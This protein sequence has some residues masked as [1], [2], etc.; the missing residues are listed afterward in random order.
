MTAA[1]VMTMNRFM[2]TDMNRFMTTTVDMNT[3]MTVAAAVRIKRG[4]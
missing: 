4:I 3:T 1:A 2:T